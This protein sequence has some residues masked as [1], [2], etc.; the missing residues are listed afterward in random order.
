MLR[1]GE[2]LIALEATVDSSLIYARDPVDGHAVIVGRQPG[3]RGWLREHCPHIGYKTA[4]RYKSIAEKARH[5]PDIK[6]A[7]ADSPN[8][9]ELQESLYKSLKLRHYTLEEPREPSRK[10]RMTAEA[11]ALLRDERRLRHLVTDVRYRTLHSLR[12]LD[13]GQHRNFIGALQTLL[14]DI[15]RT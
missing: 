3:I 1:F 6:K 7:L 14:R 11:Q 15:V 8:I 5:A 10:P 2:M 13:R 4:M 9:S 12:S